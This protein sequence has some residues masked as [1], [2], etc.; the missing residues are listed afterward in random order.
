MRHFVD[1]GID[2]AGAGPARRNA[3]Q[4]AART[5]DNERTP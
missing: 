3:A 2:M 5:H 4:A 1:I